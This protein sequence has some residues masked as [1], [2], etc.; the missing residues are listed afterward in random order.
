MTKT[1]TNVRKT[2]G[3]HLYDKNI[4]KCMKKHIQMYEKKHAYKHAY[5]CMTKS[6][7][8]MQ[9]KKRIQMSEKKHAYKH[10]YK[11]MNKHIQMYEKTRIQT[12]TNV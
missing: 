8:Q 3:M 1:P 12:L 7:I 6:C 10:A 2:T 11:C 5:K 4:Y 9:E